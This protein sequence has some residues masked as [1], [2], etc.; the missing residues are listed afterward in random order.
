MSSRLQSELSVH[1]T[2]PPC[3]HQ[4]CGGLCGRQLSH[5]GLICRLK[6]WRRSE[7]TRSTGGL[8]LLQPAIDNR[9]PPTDVGLALD[10]EAAQV[11]LSYVFI[12]LV[13]VRERYLCKAHAG[14]VFWSSR[15]L[16][17]TFYVP[18]SWH[19]CGRCCSMP[20][21]C[22]SMAGMVAYTHR[23]R[24]SPHE[25]ALHFDHDGYTP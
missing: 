12:T 7:D 13:G 11:K 22:N 2:V 6:H 14:V 20:S 19:R 16:P 17:C 9:F 3:F 8:V 25:Q 24:R 18:S 21:K 23:S 5:R 15:R 4:T 1:P 10:V